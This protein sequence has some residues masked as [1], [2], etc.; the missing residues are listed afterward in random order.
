[1]QDIQNAVLA[2]EGDIF[3]DKYYQD[4][5]ISRSGDKW[6]QLLQIWKYEF[7][8]LFQIEDYG[9]NNALNEA[10]KLNSFN[11]SKKEIEVVKNYCDGALKIYQMIR[12]FDLGDKE[13]KGTPIDFNTD[14]YARFDDYYEDY[15]FIK[16]Y[17]AFRNYLTKKPYSEEK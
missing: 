10:E 7:D 4:N 12:Y 16:Y 6:Q 2:M 1:L 5:I 3:K 13:K 11:K 15:E 14:F 8:S 17:N 9:Y